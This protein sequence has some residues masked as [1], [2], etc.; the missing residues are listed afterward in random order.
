M[1]AAKTGH[2]GDGRLHPGL[3][4]INEAPPFDSVQLS[5]TQRHFQRDLVKRLYAIDLGLTN[6]GALPS[7]IRWKIQ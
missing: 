7:K 6:F 3:S 4:I 1:T 5:A 2:T